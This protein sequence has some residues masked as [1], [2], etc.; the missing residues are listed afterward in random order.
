MSKLF[1]KETNLV[2]AFLECLDRCRWSGIDG[3]PMGAGWTRYPE[4]AGWDLL[5]SHDETGIQVG[6]EAKLSLNAKV[7]L[8]ALPAHRWAAEIGPDYRAV[9]VPADACQIG[10]AGLAAQLGVKVIKISAEEVWGRS[11]AP[12]MQ[13]RCDVKLPDENCRY[14]NCEWWP[15]L[16]AESE[17]LPEYVPDCIAGAPSPVAL[18]LWKIKAIRLM[19]LLERNGSVTRKDMKAL[20]ISSSRW[21]APYHGFLV[22]GPDRGGWIA[23]PRTPDLR[24]QHPRNWAEIEADFDLWN[25]DRVEAAA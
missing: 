23:G 7:L 20:D 6:I 11:D 21:T 25:P 1:A 24:A 2:A 12:T 18:T 8:Q 15:W 13:W 9:L 22:P 5:L 14:S 19:I 17:K 3:S 10:T 4:T 16:P